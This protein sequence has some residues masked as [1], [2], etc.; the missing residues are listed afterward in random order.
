MALFLLVMVASWSPVDAKGSSKRTKR[1]LK[2]WNKYIT[3]LVLYM[4]ELF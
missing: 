2:L 4:I 3:N 1:L